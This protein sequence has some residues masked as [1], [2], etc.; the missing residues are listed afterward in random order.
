MSRTGA[1]VAALATIAYALVSAQSGDQLQAAVRQ[2]RAPFLDTLRELVSIESGSRDSE[3][4]R[5]IAAL[6]AARLAALGG[7]VEIIPPREIVRMDDTP[8]E[9]GSSVVARFRGTGTRRVLLLAHMDTVYLKGMLAQQRFRIDGDRAYGLGIADDKHGVALI[10]HTL[11]VLRATNVRDYGLI[12]VLINGDEEVS[13]PGSRSLITRLGSEHDV[14]LSLE[15]AGEDDRIRLTTSGI[16]AVLLRVTGRSAH[17]GSA[18]EM[19]R[20]ALYEL[21]HQMLQ[22]R[23]LSDPAAGVKVNWTLASAGSNRNVIPERAQATADVRVV[24]VSDYDLV[25]RRVKERVQKR[26]IPDTKVEV[27]FE[28]RRPPL[29]ASAASTR[30]AEH[31]RRIYAEIGKTLK[32]DDVSPGGGTDAAFAALETKAPV[33]EGLGLQGYG[34]HSNAAEYVDLRSIEPRMYLLARLIVD[35]AR[36]NTQ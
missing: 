32:V 33:I 30:L 2:E 16:G 17:A 18:P 20:N 28:R 9:I 11:S 26:L 29:E 10:L 22:M 35:V 24:K 31:A 6:I 13:S 21:A 34:A 8:P 12:T 25:E 14:V 23:D 3:G 1:A 15:G 5:R 19:G 7:A 4:L 27:T 36:G